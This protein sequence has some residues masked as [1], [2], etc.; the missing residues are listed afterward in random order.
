VSRPARAAP[1]LAIIA[2]HPIQYFSPWYRD[3]ASRPDLAIRVFYLWDFGVASRYDEGF[4]RSIQWDIPLLSGYEHEFVPNRSPLPDTRRFFGL[5][6]PSI[7]RRIQESRPSAVL[8]L[9]YNF[10]TFLRVIFSRRL[11]N[12]PLLF[13]GDSHRLIK[14]R[15]IKEFV[16]RRLITLVF[17]RIS[18]FLYVGS[19]NREY[20]KHHC[21]PDSKLFL[22]PHAVDNNRFFSQSIDPARE[23]VAFRKSLD[24]S[25]ENLVILFAGKFEEKKRPLDLLTAFR[26]ARLERASLIFVGSGELEGRLRATAGELSNVHFAPF[27]NQT[28]MPSIYAAADV[29]VLP[30]YGPSETW[31]LAVNEAMCMSRAVIVSDHVGCAMDLVVHGYNGLVFAAGDVSALT[32][33][34]REAASDRTRLHEW[35]QHGREMIKDYS[36]E[37]STKGLTEALSS[38]GIL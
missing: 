9:G 37:Q 25:E 5:W 3:L 36:Y 33:C 38:L 14:R 20:F 10:A 31:G 24:I 28:F 4:Q 30:S 32:N 35:G 7:I 22:S 23:A 29:F 34:L 13:R 18:A 12:V 8:L 17:R 21:V 1:L 26:T 16:R 27:Q 2:T 11:Q 19:A 15:G 6:N